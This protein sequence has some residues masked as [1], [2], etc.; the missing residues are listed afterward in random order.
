[1]I[2]PVNKIQPKSSSSDKSFIR[3]VI[4]LIKIACN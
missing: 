3:Q 4:R 2:N 1:M